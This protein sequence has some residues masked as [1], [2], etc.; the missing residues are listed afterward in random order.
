MK[1]AQNKE[2]QYK[3]VIASFE[4]CG[5]NLNTDNKSAVN[6]KTDKIITIQKIVPLFIVE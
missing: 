4:L 3:N 6:E 5:V 2:R 1:R